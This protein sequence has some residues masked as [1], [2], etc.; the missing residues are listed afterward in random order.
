[1]S[2]ADFEAR[3]DQL[4]DVTR[5]RARHIITENVRVLQAAEAMRRG[6]AAGLG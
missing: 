3:A 2:L 1:V 4:E 6:D 5:R